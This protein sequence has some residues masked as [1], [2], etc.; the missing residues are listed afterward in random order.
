MYTY[1]SLLKI[2]PWAMYLS[3]SSKRGVGIFSRTLSF[4]N[5]PTPF[6][7]R[8]T[9]VLSIQICNVIM[10]KRAAKQYS[11]NTST[12]S[13]FASLACYLHPRDSCVSI[14]QPP[15]LMRLVW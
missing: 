4:E 3:G 9:Q 14:A 7:S 2:C 5:R 11:K 6:K 8:P 13:L 1:R 15:T 12:S 10:S